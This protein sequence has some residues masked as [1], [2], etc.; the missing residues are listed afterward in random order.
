MPQI[1]AADDPTIP[2]NLSNRA[3][4]NALPADDP[5]QARWNEDLEDEFFDQVVH[6]HVDKLRGGLIAEPRKCLQVQPDGSKRKLFTLLM[7]GQD[8]KAGHWIGL[9]ND[10]QKFLDE[11]YP[12]EDLPIRVFEVHMGEL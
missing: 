4:T 3:F 11:H 10:A 9:Y 2:E 7:G 6:M 5:I 1:K 12:G 8:I